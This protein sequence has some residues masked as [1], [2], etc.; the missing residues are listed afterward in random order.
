[1][2]DEKRTTFTK[3]VILPYPTPY[4][5]LHFGNFTVLHVFG[6][7]LCFSLLQEARNSRIQ[8]PCI[9][10]RPIHPTAHTLHYTRPTPYNTRHPTLH[11]QPLPPTYLYPL[12]TSHPTT[13]DILPISHPTMPEILHNI[14]PTPHFSHCAHPTPYT[15]FLTLRTPHTLQ[16]PTPYQPHTL[17]FFHRTHPTPCNALHPA[18]ERWGAGVETQKKV[19]GEIG[20]WGRVP[21]NEPYAP[22]L[23]TIYDGA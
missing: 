6:A 3:I 20:G 9:A 8:T 13:P 22:S 17:H 1:M 21:F 19:W 23:S 5:H 7:V 2:C 16:H 10:C 11:Q 12:H 4:P 18:Y 14:H 15:S